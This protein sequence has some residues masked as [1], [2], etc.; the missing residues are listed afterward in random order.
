MIYRMRMGAWNLILTTMLTIPRLSRQRLRKKLLRRDCRFLKSLCSVFPFLTSL[1]LT[2]FFRIPTV[3]LLR[4][5][6][7]NLSSQISC[8]ISCCF[9]FLSDFSEE[10]IRKTFCIHFVLFVFSEYFVRFCYFHIYYLNKTVF[11]LY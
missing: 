1:K 2:F 3:I 8:H 5:L 11:M 9:S 6:W 10:I 7:E 4:R